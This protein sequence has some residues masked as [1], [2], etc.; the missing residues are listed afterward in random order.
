MNADVAAGAGH[1]ADVSKPARRQA[2]Q[3]YRYLASNPSE[4]VL[5]TDPD[6]RIQ[7]ASPSVVDLLGLDEQHVIGLPVADL[8]LPGDREVL[9]TAQGR[10]TQTGQSIDPFRCTL[11][12]PAG[13]VSW[14]V[15][16]RPEFAGQGQ[17]IGLVVTLVDKPDGESALRALATL[18][19][20][21][22][23]LV[24]AADETE[25]LLQMCRTI[26]D[27][28]GY[29]LAWY[30]R[31]VL[32]EKKSVI[33]VAAAGDAIGYL[34]EIHVSWADD[35]FGNGPTGRCL[36]LG[37]TQV[38]NDFT[39]DPQ[40]SPWKRSADRHGLHCSISVP[41]FVENH[42]DGALVVYDR[43]TGAFDSLAQTLL[44]DIAADLGLGIARLRSHTARE[45]AV[46][47][48][49]ASESRYRL[50]AE[51]ASDVILLS[52]A[53]MNLTW[54][55]ASAQH[56]LGWSVEEL[57][58]RPASEFIHPDDLPALRNKVAVSER[59]RE[60]VR[61]RYRWRCAD[62]TYL[63]MEAI[64]RPISD[65][66]TGQRGRVVALRNID[67]QVR[68]ERELS[69]R[70]AR[71]RLLA[72]NASDIVWEISA[73]GR[74]QWVSPSVTRVI[75]WSP[76]EILGKVA[77]DLVDPLDRE[78][79][80]LMRAKVFHGQTAAGEVR[81]QTSSGS[82]RWM[83][84][85]IRPVITDDGVARIATL[86]DIESEVQA[87]QSLDFV[88]GH[89]QLTGLPN[90]EHIKRRI[91][92]ERA[93]LLPG[94]AMAVLCVGVDGLAQVNEAFT[95]SAGD[96]V[97]TT[98]AVRIVGATGEPDLVGRS[99]GDEFIVVLADLQAESDAGE[100]AE[101]IR[102]AIAGPIEV[103]DRTLMVTASIGL[104]TGAR[105]IPTDQLLRNATLALRRAK[106]SGRDRC[107]FADPAMAVEAQHQLSLG[108]EI[109]AALA[110]QQLRAWFQPIVALSDSRV[111]GYEALVR[112]E[113][114][115]GLRM[116]GSFLPVAERSSLICEI[117]VAM[118]QQAVVAL[119]ELPADMFISVN[120]SA[121]T[122]SRMSY[123]DTAAQVLADHSVDPARLHLEL[124]ETALLTLDAQVRTT[125]Q[126]LRG[127]GVKWYVDDFGTGYSSISHLRDLPVDGLKLDM[128]FTFGLAQGDPTAKRLAVGLVGL[129]RGMGLDTVAEGVETADVAQ[130]L[131]AMGWINAQ[132]WLYGKAAAL[133]V[134]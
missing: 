49:A 125:M 33:E 71:Y 92:V 57:A 72:E 34:K 79:L 10:V 86:R 93:R 1:H 76:E 95:H 109:R 20:A 18:S 31:I 131:A 43:H 111:R 91:D 39:P 45:H 64:G 96:I 88:L 36:R 66:G 46:R 53:A 85:T 4:V 101:D 80:I 15:R 26:A 68:A 112:W 124:T 120:V 65:D 35:A 29:T 16:I 87:R 67:A 60:Q 69:E 55:S 132:G 52:D 119:T 90:L 103:S 24:R 128:S 70:E 123:A 23:C 41:V 78:S 133:P 97:L 73:D 11:D 77:L 44:E 100:L 59:G 117:D 81:I 126:R 84:L 116:P 118:L 7:W 54:V 19:Q 30:G 134:A 56:V 102:K 62:G 114:H 75:G 129:A 13:P 6:G 12:T 94:R 106:N 63:W 121:N 115:E 22:R 5:G 32:D 17:V 21:N 122:L 82:S 105:N 50:L 61:L 40:F 127:F 8:A 58:G 27:V 108:Q 2:W 47:D 3:P 99:T 28:G 104:A 98:V 42:L 9:L 83:A 48:L 89:D 38:E 74:L 14:N 37:Q 51:N 25:L 113:H 110:A 130:T 107:S